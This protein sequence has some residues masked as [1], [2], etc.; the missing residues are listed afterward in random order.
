M[1]IYQKRMW[2]SIKSETLFFTVCRLIFDCILI[3][4]HKVELLALEICVLRFVQPLTWRLVSSSAVFS[5]GLLK[6]FKMAAFTLCRKT[7]SVTA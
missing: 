1:S 2:V 4:Y 6:A 5:V 3:Y 7:E